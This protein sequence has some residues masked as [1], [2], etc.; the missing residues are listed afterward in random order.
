MPHHHSF[1]RAV[2]PSLA[3]A[4]L[5]LSAGAAAAAPFSITTTGTVTSGSDSA[6]LLGAGTSLVGDSYALT[7]NFNGLGPSY[8]TD[9]TGQFALDVGDAILGSIR[10]TIA[11]H[12]TTT[13]LA[14]N[15]AATLSEDT[16]DLAATNSGNAA[17]NSF[18]FGSQSITGAGNFVPFADLQT[19]FSYTLTAGDVGLDIYSFSNAANTHTASFNGT[20]RSVQFS[21]AA[22]VPEPA[23]LALL[24]AGLAGL[25]LARR[26]TPV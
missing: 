14:A 23:T 2:A 1:R 11:G 3:V 25:V 4:A 13:T 18:A 17:D 9:G 16:S 26:R 21:L 12:T 8:F 10:V 15:P 5:L 19:P 6:N 22:A 24:G 20:T 7:L